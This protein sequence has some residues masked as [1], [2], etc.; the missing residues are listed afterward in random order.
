MPPVNIY[1]CRYCCLPPHSQS[2]TLS[3]SPTLVS[4]PSLLGAEDPSNSCST[5]QWRTWCSCLG[6]VCATLL[7]HPAMKARDAGNL[8]PIQWLRTQ[9]HLFL[10]IPTVSLVSV[11]PFPLGVWLKK[12]RSLPPCPPQKSTMCKLPCTYILNF[13]FLLPEHLY[14]AWGKKSGSYIIM[15]CS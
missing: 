8:L 12:S 13:S 7:L 11:A 4:C 9:I 10:D 14:L 1:L 5:G 15:H 2:H 6:P 3:V